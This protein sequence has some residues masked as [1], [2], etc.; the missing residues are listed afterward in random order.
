MCD[1]TSACVWG[2][3]VG[4]GQEDCLAGATKRYWGRVADDPGPWVVEK[5]GSHKTLGFLWGSEGFRAV[6]VDRAT[7]CGCCVWL[8]GVLCDPTCG[9]HCSLYAV[10]VSVGLA[11]AEKYEGVRVS[12]KTPILEK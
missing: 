4:D 12:H 7:V 11:S 10:L 5:V 1:P 2:G 8:Y 6:F 3:R 9:R